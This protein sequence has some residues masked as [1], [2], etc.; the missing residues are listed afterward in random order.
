M[1]SDSKCPFSVGESVIYRPS[2]K[3]LAL[4]VMA[5]PEGRLTPGSQYKI[6]SIEKESY[7]VVAGYR[8]PGGGLYWTEFERS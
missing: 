5:S 4:D 6:T 3:G 1:N 7:V 8:H 2:E